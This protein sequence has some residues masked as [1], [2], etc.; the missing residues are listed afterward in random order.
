MALGLMATGLS[1]AKTT[2]RWIDWGGEPQIKANEKIKAAFE[3]KYPDIEVKLEFT[4]PS[5]DT[6]IDK[7]T[8]Q[9][10]GG[11]APDVITAWTE[12][13]RAWAEKGQ[14]LDLTPYVEKN[15]DPEV[16][17]DLHPSVMHALSLN[18]VQY[19]MP[20]YVTPMAIVYNKDAFGEAGLSNPTGDWDWSEFLGDAKKLTK[21]ESSGFIERFGFA[22]TDQIDR[23]VMWVRQN[24]GRIEAENGK[25]AMDSPEAIEAV[26]FM[27][28]MRWKHHVVPKPSD[29]AGLGTPQ[30]FLNGLAA[31]EDSGSWILPWY[32]DAADFEWDVTDMPHNKQR[33]TM[34]TVDGYS[35][36]KGSEHPD[37]AFKLIQFLMSAEAQRIL[38]ADSGMAPARKS[39]GYEFAG[40]F[41]NYNAEVFVD[42]MQYAG[43]QPFF[44]NMG[45]VMEYYTPAMEKILELN[46]GDTA[47]ILRDLTQK[48]NE[49]ILAQ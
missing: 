33:F 32:R 19:G 26:Q 42:A 27:R 24:D 22:M 34:H 1:Q 40:E 43:P 8:T 30:T 45:E 36:W 7:L 39:I 28:D 44:K 15:M 38:M 18:G 11:V 9:M 10:V 13:Y 41:P 14:F 4:N 29:M 48:V 16:V 2:I 46:D 25:M 12:T 17:N 47:E 37:A 20:K 5:G 23:H 31:M 6:W 21:G 3:A 49:E 35:I